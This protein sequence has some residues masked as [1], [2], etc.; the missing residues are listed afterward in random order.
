MW[1]FRDDGTGAGRDAVGMA[2]DLAIPARADDSSTGGGKRVLV[3]YA[4]RHG[5]TR[6]IAERLGARLREAGLAVEI[7]D[8]GE[9]GSVATFAAVVLGAPVY[10]GRWPSEASAF[11]TR[12]RNA[13]AQR[14]LWLFSVG[15]FGDTKRV[16]GPLVLREPRDIGQLRAALAPREYRVFAG[17]VTRGMWPLPSRMLYHVFGGRL[18][19]HRDWDAI[20]AW[21]RG[22][23]ADLA[24]P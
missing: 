7:A 21:G 22:I 23:A 1:S 10:D 8:V 6:G 13:L 16:I 4:S 15:S 19:D 17:I 12:E 11:A 18:G 20:D 5:S 14:P 9:I 24:S 2:D 3:A